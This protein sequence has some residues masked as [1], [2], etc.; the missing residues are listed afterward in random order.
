MSLVRKR[1][2][3]GDVMMSLGTL[4]VLVAILAAYDDR[5]RQEVMLRVNGD[6]SAQMATRARRP[7]RC[8]RWSS[9]C[10][11]HSIEHAPMVIFVVLAVVRSGSCCGHKD[12]CR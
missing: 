4:A 8:W 1:A 11:D 9:P 10:A 7:T 12:I 3:V 5:M 2:V 6:P